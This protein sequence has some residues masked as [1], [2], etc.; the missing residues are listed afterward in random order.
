[1]A[2]TIKKNPKKR[3]DWVLIENCMIVTV[4][5]DKDFNRLFTCRIDDENGMMKITSG[6]GAVKK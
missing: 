5:E 3:E 2:Y 1:M 4:E 6:T